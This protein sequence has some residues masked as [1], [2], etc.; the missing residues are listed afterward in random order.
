M[1]R[2]R[3]A[4]TGDAEWRRILAQVD[5]W[6]RP[7]FPLTGDDVIRAGVPKGPAVGQVLADVEAWWID[8]GFPSDR[9]VLDVPLQSA[10]AKVV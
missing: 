9:A 10:I 4:M 6:Q 7:L 8:A 5:N 1:D 3:L 2:V